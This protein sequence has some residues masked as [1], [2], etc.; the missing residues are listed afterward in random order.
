MRKFFICD[1]CVSTKSTCNF[2]VLDVETK[3]E[4]IGT[5][6]LAWDRLGA[7]DQKD[8]DAFELMYGEIDDAGIPW[9]DEAE[10]ITKFK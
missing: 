9:L 4:A 2:D 1:D 5:A 10:T 3:E 8:R 6:Q 7:H